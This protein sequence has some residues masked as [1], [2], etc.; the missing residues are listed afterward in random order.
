MI[1]EGS[2]YH[3]SSLNGTNDLIIRVLWRSEDESKIVVMNTTDSDEMEFP[4]IM[5]T[6]QLISDLQQK[7]ALKLDHEPDQQIMY[8]TD[9]YLNKFV[10]SRDS[11]WEL[12]K[13]I[14]QMEPE[15]YDP[16][17]RWQLIIGVM[18]KFKVKENVIYDA[19]KRYW[20][21]GK[22][23]NGL[24]N[25]YH[26]CGSKGHKRE[27]NKRPGRKGPNIYLLTET[28]IL[29]FQ[30]AVTKYI[31]EGRLKFRD[32]HQQL[33]ENYYKKPGYRLRGVIV[34][35]IVEIEAPSERQFRYWYNKEYPFKTRKAH[36]VGRRNA[37]K[38]FR[39]LLSSN[40]V[41]VEGPGALY[42]IDSTPSDVDVVAID[43]RTTIGRPTTFIV[44]DVFARKVVGYSSGLKHASWIEGAMMALE[45]A[46]ANKAE[47][48]KKFNIDINEED[49]PAANLPRE[50][51]ADRGEMKSK[52]PNGIVTLG[53][54]V[55]NT[56][57]YRPE[58]KA[59][60]EQH[61]RI[62][63]DMIKRILAKA[64]AITKEKRDPGDPDPSDTAAITFDTFNRI[65][66]EHILAFNKMSLPRD[67]LVTPEMF[68]ENVELTPNG[69]WE[70]GKKRMLLHE[71]PTSTIHYALLP[72]ETAKVTRHGIEF[73]KLC[74]SCEIGEKQGWFDSENIEG[75]SSITI[76]FDT[77]NCSQI[78][79][80]LQDASLIYC[81]L[82]PKYQ[83]YENLCFED[84]KAIFDF[85][86]E[87]YKNKSN[88]NKQTKAEF[89]AISSNVI[90][91]DVKLT[92]AENVGMSKFEKK[93]NKRA[94][95]IS[96]AMNRSSQSALTAVS[97]FNEQYE[98]QAPEPVEV[99]KN[100]L[101]T[102][103]NDFLKNKYKM[104][105][106]MGL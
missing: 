38:D 13:E 42:Q 86:N 28:D 24:L 103:M 80:Q 94:K 14:V 7:K 33:L 2:I 77:R 4:F 17:A 58:L 96:E 81:R 37:E 101:S 61:F 35:I 51:V 44:K 78:I 84:V 27:Y 55:A 102:T 9:E 29:N 3:L 69:L 87:Q 31:I 48:C 47:Y 46:S 89:N 79:F 67:F 93:E 15:I 106:E 26:V 22:N 40:S 100:E 72:K 57:S 30:E 83:E 25:N 104:K 65:M 70:W 56:P 34:P 50:I 10:K 23:M 41:F 90:K 91:E 97:K 32:A 88:P 68:K 54:R 60:V 64:G 59:V 52:Y 63:N 8:P 76:A 105:K 5:N 74:Y 18:E 95:R 43:G 75:K 85:R 53:I 21:Y 66:I 98:S 99:K 73:K 12:I 20:F 19:L 62:K 82:T 36:K 71:R 39:A 1:L 6:E 11:K 45:N 92:K 49:W 16:K